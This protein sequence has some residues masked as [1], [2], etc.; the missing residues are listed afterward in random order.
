MRRTTPCA[1]QLWQQANIFRNDDLCKTLKFQPSAEGAKAGFLKESSKQTN[2]LVQP[3]LSK[4]VTYQSG[5]FYNAI[6]LWLCAKLHWK[7]IHLQAFISSQKALI[8]TVFNAILPSCHTN[9][10]FINKRIHL[11]MSFFPLT[12]HLALYIVHICCNN[13]NNYFWANYFRD[14]KG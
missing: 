7:C 14:K 6:N 8:Q 13:Y 2:P 4:Q 5:I 3:Q 9:S 1:V 11:V 10:K 12:L